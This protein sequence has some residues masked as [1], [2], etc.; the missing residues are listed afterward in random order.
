[1][2][3][4]TRVLYTKYYKDDQ[5]NKLKTPDRSRQ[6]DIKEAIWKMQMRG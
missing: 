1:M 2:T 6:L 4:P 5:I 3:S